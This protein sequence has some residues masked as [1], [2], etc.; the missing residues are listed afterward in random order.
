MSKNIRITVLVENSVHIRGLKAEHGLSFLIEIGGHRVLFD[1]GQS[2]LLLENARLLGCSMQD[3]DVVVMSH[4]HDDHTGG[5]AAVC[6]QS[7]AAQ[8]FL[9]PAAMAPK[10][11]VNP[12]GS[13]RYIG[14]PE[15][16]KQAAAS[17][18]KNLVL[19]PACQLVVAG[20]FVTGE[21][22][23]QTDFEDVGG[24]FFLD[25]HCQTPDPLVDD[26]ALFFETS[27]GVVVLLGCAHAGVVNTLLHI[28]RLTNGKRFH[29]VLGGMHLL[30]AS[31]ARLNATIEML[32]RWNVA[33]LVPLHCT[34]LAAVAR[35]WEVFPG[36]C[37]AAGV[38][39]RFVF[40]D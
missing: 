26:Q 24:R 25:E 38:G 34:G 19:T 14:M 35:L 16:A 33:Q 1:T 10:F 22:P 36:C 37:A 8:L 23:R 28:E 4:G 2:E 18:G 39:S 6:R 9:N 27:E 29:A 11:G 12:D 21:I 15:E 40:E 32:R 17:A 30:N 31:P 7:P 3:L 5:L 13:A 20:L